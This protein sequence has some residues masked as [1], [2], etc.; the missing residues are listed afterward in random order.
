[1]ST[2][3][4]SSAPILD[5]DATLLIYL[6]VFFLLFFLL[7]AFVFRPTMELF[8]ERERAIDGARQEARDLE[9]EAEGKLTSF[10]EQM[11]KVRTEASAERDRLRAEGVRL[12]R[13]LT[14]KVRAETDQ[15]VRD[16]EA[17]MADEAAKVRKDIAESSPVLA[18]E[19]AEKLLG[20]EVGR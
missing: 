6:G 8:D 13:S 5:V 1:M 15:V 19:I 7:R 11:G 4:L 14:E 3:L 9:R 18:R 20:R 17:R 2:V 10:E 12:E 16:A